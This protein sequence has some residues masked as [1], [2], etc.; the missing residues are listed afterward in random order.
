MSTPLVGSLL[1]CH[2]PLIQ[3][4]SPGM[5]ASN[6]RCCPGAP[7]LKIVATSQELRGGAVGGK[8]Q[9]G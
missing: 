7:H 6:L 3:L 5:T 8:H 4:T 1:A 9:T 2:K